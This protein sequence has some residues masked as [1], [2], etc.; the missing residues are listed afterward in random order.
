MYQS[1]HIRLHN[2]EGL[3]AY[4][5]LSGILCRACIATQLR[6]GIFMSQRK[7]DLLKL[8]MQNCQSL[9]AMTHG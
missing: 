3:P 2:L 4:W 7:H 9:H 8:G 5:V 1:S 6:G